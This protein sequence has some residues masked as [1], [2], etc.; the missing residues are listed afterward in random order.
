VP[1]WASPSSSPFGGAWYAT[2]A[3]YGFAGDVV[4]P[5]GAVV[6]VPLRA[7]S[8]DAPAGSHGVLVWCGA[9]WRAGAWHGALD[10]LQWFVSLCGALQGVLTARRD[11]DVL[12]WPAGLPGALVA[13]GGHGAHCLTCACEIFSW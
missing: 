2:V 13:A 3:V 7:A 1:A 9:A 5:V 6:C 8:H 4:S 12:A 11:A 10:A